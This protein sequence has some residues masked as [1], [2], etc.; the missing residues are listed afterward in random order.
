MNFFLSLSRLIHVTGYQPK[1]RA[2]VKA[3]LSVGAGWFVLRGIPIAPTIPGVLLG[4]GVFLGVYGALILLTGALTKE[5]IRWILGMARRK[6]P[7]C[8]ESGNSAL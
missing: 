3:A 8:P 2:T 7:N 1:F 6:K 4:G 5:D